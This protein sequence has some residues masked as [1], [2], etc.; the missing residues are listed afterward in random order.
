[1]KR[2][3]TPMQFGGCLRLGMFV[4]AVA[5]W[6]VFVGVSRA[7]EGLELRVGAAAVNVQADDSMVI[8][9]GIGPGRAGGQEGLLRAVAVVVQGP[10]G[11]KICHRCL[12]C[13][14]HSEGDR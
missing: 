9:G 13:V 12:R 8:A 1:M 2:I 10:E 11:T 3:Q 4:P 7:R 14:V 6:I 5:A